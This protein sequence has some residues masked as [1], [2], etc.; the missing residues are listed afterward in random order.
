MELLLSSIFGYFSGSIPTAYLILKY[1]YGIDIRTTGSGNVGAMNSFEVTKSKKTGIIVLVIDFF[2]GLLPL[3][4]VLFFIQKSF[5][6]GALTLCFSV[7]AH[8][9]SP[10]LGFKG[11]KGLATAS[12]GALILSPFILAGWLFVWISLYSLRRDINLINFITSVIIWV[13]SIIFVNLFPPLLTNLSVGASEFRI[14]VSL[15][16]L[17][18]L[19]KHFG[20]MRCLTGNKH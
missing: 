3:F 18:I 10:W 15:L 8:C 20:Y 13:F 14:F 19:S 6:A 17:I 12:G 4:F 11:G 16:F 1:F 5:S 7:F 2:K 9:Y